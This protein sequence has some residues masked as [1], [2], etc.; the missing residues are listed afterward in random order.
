[1]E[2]IEV[3]DKLKGHLILTD[4]MKK[5]IKKFRSNTMT[6]KFVKK[7]LNFPRNVRSRTCSCY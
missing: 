6:K 2:A 3:F 4:E 1:M 5:S 7:K